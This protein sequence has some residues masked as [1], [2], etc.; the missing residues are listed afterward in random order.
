MRP[1]LTLGVLGMGPA[2]T[3][4]FLEKIEAYTPGRAER[5][6]I[7]VIA[8][9]NPHV[10]ELNTPGSGAGAALAEAAGALR[11]AGADVLAIICDAAHA[12]TALIERASRLPVIDMIDAAAKAARATGARRVGVL[13]PRAA[14]KLY[15][16][17]LAAQAMGLVSLESERQQAFMATLQ[18]VKDGDLGSA[19]RAEMLAYARELIAAGA[20]A[21][22]AGAVEVPFVIAAAELKATLIEPAE[23]LARRSVAVCLGLEPAPSIAG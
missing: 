14:L 11:G 20:E 13:G 1:P 15:R 4:D 2:A 9:I 3:L 10:P 8:D 6:H 19:R 7:R 16:E 12:H 17:Y 18:S 5:E 21:V 22:I 23:V